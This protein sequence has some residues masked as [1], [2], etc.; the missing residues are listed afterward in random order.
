M[1]KYQGSAAA[2]KLPIKPRLDA[3][4]RGITILESGLDFQLI[5]NLIVKG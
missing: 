5:F 4:K 2:T 3:L 1:S